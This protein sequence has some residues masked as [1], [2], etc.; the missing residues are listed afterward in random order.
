MHEYWAICSQTANLRPEITETITL[1]L[2]HLAMKI[3]KQYSKY[4]TLCVQKLYNMV[5][6]TEA[7]FEQEK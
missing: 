1:K 7:K 2:K 3:K 6:D 4:D 5:M